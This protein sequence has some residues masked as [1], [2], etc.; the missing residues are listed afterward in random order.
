MPM[1]LFSVYVQ[2]YNCYCIGIALLTL[3]REFHSPCVSSASLRGVCRSDLQ[4]PTTA[5]LNLRN[6]FQS[7]PF[8]TMS[9]DRCISINKIN[10]E[11]EKAT[12]PNKLIFLFIHIPLRY[13]F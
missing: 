9:S 13:I 8:G 4:T 10:F 3:M 12:K 1:L 11:I 5:T 6:F 2:S 7:F